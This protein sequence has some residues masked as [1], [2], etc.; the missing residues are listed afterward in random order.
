[1]SIVEIPRAIK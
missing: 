1:P